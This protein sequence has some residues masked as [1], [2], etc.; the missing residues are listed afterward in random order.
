MTGAVSDDLKSRR[1]LASFESL[2]GANSNLYGVAG[3]RLAAAT[4]PRR[5]TPDPSSVNSNSIHPETAPPMTSG[6]TSTAPSPSAV[7]VKV[8]DTVVSWLIGTRK[9][10][11][12]P[13]SEGRR[14]G[15]IAT[16][17]VN[18]VAAPAHPRI[19]I[20]HTV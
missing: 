7:M 4:P 1:N 3:T 15:G 18:A 9:L 12:P 8:W 2:I 10:R 20:G 5:V 16:V 14:T 13:T 19:Q 11:S 6:R 17:T